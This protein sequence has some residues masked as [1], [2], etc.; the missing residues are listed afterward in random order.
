MVLEQYFLNPQGLY[1]LLIL[2]PFIILY[3]IR[4][5]PRKKVIPSLMFLVKGDKNFKNN[6]FFQTFLFDLLFFLQLLALL[7]L[8]LAIARPYFWGSEEISTKNVI[9][10]I[11]G[12]ASMQTD[13][14]GKTRFASAIDFAKDHLGEQNAVILA[15]VLPSLKG[16]EK[17]RQETKLIL[18]SLA[19][20]DAPGDV[21][22]AMLFAGGL[23]KEN[24]EV[25]VLSDF[26]SKGD[27]VEIA[28]KTLEAQGAAVSLI[29]VSEPTMNVGIVEVKAAE[30]TTTVY[31]KNYNTREENVTVSI[32][33]KVEGVPIK[34]KFV[35][36]YTFVTP[37]NTTTIS[38]LGRDSFSLDNTFY[39]SAPEQNQIR[40]LMI[41]NQPRN[42]LY[43]ALSSVPKVN[44]TI[45]EPPA[46]IK[47]I[48]HDIIV[49]KGIDR[50]LTLPSTF[51]AIEDAVQ[52]GSSLI[53]AAQDDLFLLGITDLLPL[54]FTE[55]GNNRTYLKKSTD[56]PFTED[57]EFGFVEEY[58][59]GNEKQGV[60]SIVTTENNN[61]II[62]TQSYGSGKILYYGIMDNHADFKLTPSYPLFW[63]NAVQ[64]LSN[65]V[66]V[67][68]LN[69]HTGEII[70]FE[71]ETEI[72]TP[73]D[74]RKES[75]LVLDESGIYEYND[76]IISANLVNLEE[77]DVSA[78]STINTV[79][80]EGYDLLKSQKEDEKELDL[81]F[82]FAG[83]V[84][85]LLELIYIKLRGDC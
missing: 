13:Q 55:K 67:Q 49:V 50:T 22:D 73:T 25:I 63:Y 44:I 60:V 35:E 58:L 52:Q 8:A 18:N 47:D 24:T 21:S 84:F 82:I 6:A 65:R 19:P 75:R 34:P 69:H 48:D 43:Y 28:R 66:E 15:T 5:K 72:K 17:G 56:V 32:N 31:I 20:T 45:I 40:I 85:I 30:D 2:V 79:R 77:S 68:S 27:E 62:T 12:S 57:I 71:T 76:R 41:T 36:P 1:A 4:P 70:T 38:L 64:F 74:T 51:M 39:L 11:D 10:V 9:L 80:S 54:S 37:P 61:P 59:K 23:L 3:L 78:V 81:W 29:D 42:H 53:I 33:G 83:I 26:K 7:I 46:T 14:N 16:E